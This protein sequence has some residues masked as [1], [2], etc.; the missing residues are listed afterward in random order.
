MLEFAMAM[1]IFVTMNINIYKFMLYLF[2]FFQ[3]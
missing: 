3:K 2:K 1:V